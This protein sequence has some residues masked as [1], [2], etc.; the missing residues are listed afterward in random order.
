MIRDFHHIDDGILVDPCYPKENDE[1]DV[2]D[3]YTECF[4]DFVD[5]A[6]RVKLNNVTWLIPHYMCEE[7]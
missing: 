4:V 5:I 2:L 7:I 3:I 6:Y 1:F